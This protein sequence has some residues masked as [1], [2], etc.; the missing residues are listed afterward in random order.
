MVTKQ[1]S[2]S[3]IA[4]DGSEYVTL[5]DGAGNLVSIGGGTGGSTQVEGTVASGATDS[6]NP[7]KVGGVYNTT[8]SALTA[9]QRS[10]LQVT[11]RGSLKIVNTASDGLTQQGFL[12]TP[13]DASANTGA[14]LSSTGAFGFVFNGTTWDRARGDATAGQYVQLRA[15]TT[16]GYSFS[17]IST[18]TTTTVKSG[19]GTLHSIVINTLGTADTITVYDNT[20]GSGTKIATIN[21]ALSQSTLIYDVAFATGLTLVTA[22]TTAPDITVTYK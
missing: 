4:P 7:V 16:G 1:I 9:G 14:N 18:N 11:S 19:A 22:G 15:A 6:G 3:T 17:N 20:A 13:S 21:A 10:D 5:T 8:I 12:A 2:N